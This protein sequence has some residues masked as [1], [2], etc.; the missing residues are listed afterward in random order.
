[1]KFASLRCTS[2]RNSRDEHA[3]VQ[4]VLA[5]C[6]SP[7]RSRV[8]RVGLEF[9]NRAADVARFVDGQTLFIALAF[10]EVNFLATYPARKG[11][12][13]HQTPLTQ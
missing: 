9:H 7:G 11:F 4:K 6:L 5:E 12:G 10:A 8:W 13:S 1:M 2:T 3:K